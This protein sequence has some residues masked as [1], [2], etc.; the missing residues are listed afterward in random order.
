MEKLII[1]FVLL[2][3]IGL[4]FSFLGAIITQYAWDHSVVELFKFPEI[5]FWQA[6]CLNLLGSMVCKSSARS[7]SK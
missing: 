5:S 2:F 7:S 1:E 6:F 4:I 3:V